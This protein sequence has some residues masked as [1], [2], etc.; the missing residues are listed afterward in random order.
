MSAG[1]PIKNPSKWLFS[2]SQKERVAERSFYR[3]HLDSNGVI[4]ILSFRRFV[5]VEETR[6]F[7]LIQSD[8][9]LWHHM[10]EEVLVAEA[11]DMDSVTSD[12]LLPNLTLP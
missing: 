8:L 12:L 10:E 2:K 11:V 1:T 3:H 7:P 6:F 4:S 9:K 5:Y